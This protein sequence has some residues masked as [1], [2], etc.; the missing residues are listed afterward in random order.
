[1]QF[2]NTLIPGRL[3][4]RYKRYL[5]DIELGNG[6]VVTAHCAN[7]GAMTGIID[8]G[9]RVWLSPQP[10]PRRKLPYSWE[11]VETDTGTLVGVNTLNPNR[12]V[13]EALAANRIPELVGYEHHRRER[14]YGGRS[15]VDFLL[16]SPGRPDCFLEVKNVHMI[17]T[18]GLAEFP[19]TQSA[20]ATRHLREL[21][22]QVQAGARAVVLYVVQ[23]NDCERF[24]VAADIDPKLGE[25]TAA[26]VTAGV[27]FLSYKCYVTVSGVNLGAAL[28]V[29]GF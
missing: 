22:E 26:A 17:R 9:L 11:V 4:Q 29:E 12:I 25:A 1:M 5:A 21:A 3:V 20:R 23:R 16:E 14:P 13:A 6:T 15:R 8:P 24:R 18:A 10:D 28:R 2:D 19:D 7:P 27:E